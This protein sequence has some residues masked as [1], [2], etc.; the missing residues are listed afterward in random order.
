MYYEPSGCACQCFSLP[1]SPFVLS[2]GDLVDLPTASG[3]ARQPLPLE[4]RHTL[5]E[6]SNRPMR[7][8]TQYSYTPYSVAQTKTIPEGSQLNSRQYMSDMS[9]NRM[10][11]G[12]VGGRLGPGGAR[13]SQVILES[14][15]LGAV[16]SRERVADTHNREGRQWG[17]PR[18]SSI[19]EAQLGGRIVW[20]ERGMVAGMPVG[21]G[22][23]PQG[24][25]VGRQ[26]A[27]RQL[28]M[29]RSTGSIHD[30]VSPPPLPPPNTTQTAIGHRT[31]GADVPPQHSTGTTRMA[32]SGN[33]APQSSQASARR[34]T[35]DNPGHG[36][37]H[38]LDDSTD[39]QPYAT[40]GFKVKSKPRSN[41]LPPS[42]YDL[43]TPRQQTSTEPHE[44]ARHQ[45]SQRQPQDMANQPQG[46]TNQPQGM[47]NQPQ[48][49]VNQPRG[50]TN[51]PQGVAHQ[52]RGTA[53]QPQGM[54]Q[55]PQGTAQHPQSMGHMSHNM[56]QPQD[57]GHPPQGM[58]SQAP[59]YFPPPHVPQS[60]AG[61]GVQRHPYDVS[62]QEV[63]HGQQSNPRE[64]SQHG[65]S[66]GFPPSYGGPHR[67]ISQGPY[68]TPQPLHQ[69]YR[70]PTYT[71]SGPSVS[72]AGHMATNMSYTQPGHTATMSYPG[73]MS[74]NGSYTQQGHMTTSVLY[75]A[76]MTTS[77]TYTHP[78]HMT[79]TV[80]YPGHMTA[81]V[82]YP[83]QNRALTQVSPSSPSHP[84]TQVAP[85]P[86]LVHGPRQSFQPT[87]IPKLVSQAPP[88]TGRRYQHPQGYTTAPPPGVSHQQPQGY[89]VAPFPGISPPSADPQEHYDVLIPRNVSE[90][91][92]DGGSPSSLGSRSGEYTEQMSRAL[93]EFDSLLAPQS[94]RQI[95]QTSL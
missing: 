81:N 23:I 26:Q 89:T 86:S 39:P 94:K 33:P 95:M 45:S 1:P 85:V 14:E 4:R 22:S 55:R 12:H 42:E 5:N 13:R 20:Q 21:N 71:Q 59:R 87:P 67:S 53:N 78:G 61:P 77:V 60:R 80:S 27:T 28:S 7:P 82:S 76:R 10:P 16:E 29:S 83:Q 63:A 31:A 93:E 58:D 6:H 44:P 66:K 75:P 51:Q 72:Y 34:M 17:V 37:Q 52:P 79:T 3:T 74:T 2:L 65:Q 47:A 64:L 11:S 54:A 19:T 68:P 38:H 32:Q 41:N 62:R 35:S 9:L 91:R 49:M 73:H 15:A 43:L 48:G 69:Q 50:I 8:L 40:I 25:G 56:A 18:R 30:H 88:P 70:P 90:A 57:V 84:S 36:R 92:R 46:I 24:G